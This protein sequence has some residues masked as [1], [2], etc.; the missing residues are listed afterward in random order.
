MDEVL[1]GGRSS[2]RDQPG[3]RLLRCCARHVE[4][5]QSDGRGH[6]PGIQSPSSLRVRNTGNCLFFDTFYR[7]SER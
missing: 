7:N 5:D 2:I 1:E 4:E 3:G 6:V